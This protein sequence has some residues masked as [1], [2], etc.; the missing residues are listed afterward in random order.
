MQIAG[1]DAKHA[2]TLTMVMAT[3][4]LVAAVFMPWATKESGLVHIRYTATDVRACAGGRFCTTLEWANIG[5]LG[6][7]LRDNV[8]KALDV[9]HL[10][11][12]SRGT[13]TEPHLAAKIPHHPIDIVY[14]ISPAILPLA[15]TMLP[16]KR[17]MWRRC[18][19]TAAVAL[20]AAAVTTVLV[21]I[22]PYATNIGAGVGV[23]YA[24]VGLAA[25]AAGVG[26]RV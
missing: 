16:I 20:A 19:T 24:A 14:M 18:I 8:E 3:V 1:L 15:A 7:V 22:M 6:V 5:H 26:W 12:I 9:T 25:I 2:C 21:Q 17:A 11:T 4:L 23:S 10:D 13:L